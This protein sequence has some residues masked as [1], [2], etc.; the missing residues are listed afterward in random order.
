M[1]QFALSSNTP[2]LLQQVTQYWSTRAQGYSQSNQAELHSISQ[3]KWQAMLLSLLPKKQPLTI[4][5]VGTGPGFL[6]ILMAQ[7]G[8]NVIAVD[9]TESMLQCARE[10]AQANQVN[11]QFIQGDA[12]CLPLADA[13]IDCLIT[14]NLT[15]NLTAPEQ[16]YAE[17]Y[18]VL[19]AQGRLINFDA[20]WYRYLFDRQQEQAFLA[21][22]A[23]TARLHIADHYA[24]TDTRTMEQIARQLPLSQQ[25]R[26][27]WDLQ[28]LRQIG[29]VDCFADTQINHKLLNQEE[30]I[31]YRSTPMFMIYAQK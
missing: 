9:A 18:R 2:S 11:I 17:W 30:Q 1:S 29:F 21:D 14:R 20:N 16:A 19:N 31:N 26:P 6:A 13:S 4:L 23:T 27:Q 28:I 12:H 10:N 15:W 22:R 25:L 8:H 5:D 7:A 24:N 3:Q